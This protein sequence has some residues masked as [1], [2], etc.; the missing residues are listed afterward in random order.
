MNSLTA[1]S[2]P[3]QSSANIVLFPQSVDPTF[4]RSFSFG[5]GSTGETM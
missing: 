3:S 1:P 4:S 2:M 5:R